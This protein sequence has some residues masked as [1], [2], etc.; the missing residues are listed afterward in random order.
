MDTNRLV[1]LWASGTDDLRR[2]Q[3]RTSLGID[4]HRAVC[5]LNAQKA[6]EELGTTK[7]RHAATSLL[8]FCKRQL[9][10]MTLSFLGENKTRKRFN[11]RSSSSLDSS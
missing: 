6:K 4:F 10:P 2:S 11:D 8:V 5:W 1:R 7:A 3:C 9:N